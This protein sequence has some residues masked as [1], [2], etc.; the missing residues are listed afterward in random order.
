MSVLVVFTLTIWQEVVF[1]N[2][3]PHIVNAKI[4]ERAVDFIS[5]SNIDIAIFHNNEIKRNA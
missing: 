1:S 5:N 4:Y 3:V 2:H